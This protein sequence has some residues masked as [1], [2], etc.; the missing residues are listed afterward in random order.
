M[1]GNLIKGV[2]IDAHY[3]EPTDADD[4]LF[5]FPNVLFSPHVAGSTVDSYQNTIDACIRNIDR[6]VSDSGPLGAIV[7]TI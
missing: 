2:A 7:R 4:P 3:D 1:Q 5:A 6:A